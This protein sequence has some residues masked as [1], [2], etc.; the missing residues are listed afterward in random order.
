MRWQRLDWLF[1][2]VEREKDVGADWTPGVAVAGFGESSSDRH[3]RAYRRTRREHLRRELLVSFPSP[4]RSGLAGWHQR[5]VADNSNIY[6]H[7][8]GQAHA[9]ADY[10]RKLGKHFL[11]LKKLIRNLY[12]VSQ[13]KYFQI[14]KKNSTSGGARF[15]LM[16]SVVKYPVHLHLCSEKL[17]C[18]DNVLQRA[19][20]GSDKF[21]SAPA[22]EK[23]HIFVTTISR[24]D[25]KSSTL[26]FCTICPIEIHFDPGCS[27]KV[28][29]HI[30]EKYLAF[31]S[32]IP[33]VLP[34]AFWLRTVSH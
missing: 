21:T 1:W 14:L 32:E 15:R 33:S 12:L 23:Y 18:Q 8:N 26:C 27:V 28:R 31:C 19:C 2:V 3:Q 4:S 11:I 7:L 17:A 6:T 25:T 5:G 34:Y 20:N 30:W 16:Q 22:S 29:S 13:K 24:Y 10:N 9:P